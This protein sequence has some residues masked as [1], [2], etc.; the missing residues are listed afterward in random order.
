MI[1]NDFLRQLNRFNLIVKKRITSNYSGARKSNAIGRGVVL[2]D[3]RIYTAGDDFRAIDWKIYARTDDMHVRQYE[4]ERSLVVHTVVDCSASMDFGTPIKKFDFASMIGVG[5]A[6]LAI[7]ENEKIRFSTFSDKL[8]VFKT[9]RGMSQLIAMVDYLN[10]LKPTGKGSFKDIM[11]AYRK[12]IHSKSL[13]I[14]ISDFLY[15]IEDI[16]E[17]LLML[18]KHDLRVIQILDKGERKLDMIGDFKL[19]DSETDDHMR[20]YISPRLIAE[21]RHQLEDHIAK[22]GDTCSKLGIRFY[23]TTTDTPIFEAFHRILI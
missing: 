11:R 13:I 17:G 10:E 16:R 21:Y 12:T 6:H 14:L 7:K 2:K 15:D 9:K 8:D 20:T 18:K 1:D 22:I 5:F 19:Y 23:S 4:E 3:H